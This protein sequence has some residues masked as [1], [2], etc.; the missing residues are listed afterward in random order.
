MKAPRWLEVRV[1]EGLQTLLT[2]RLRN[3]PAADTIEAV[4]EVWLAV[5]MSRSVRWEEARDAPR[6]RGAFL[7]I[8]GS[9]DFWPAPAQVFAAM[10]PPP[11][12]PRLTAPRPGPIPAEVRARLD[13]LLRSM[14][15]PKFTP[16]E[17]P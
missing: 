12:L 16:G 10:P 5:F 14:R 1:I 7:S 6:I 15:S 4:M 8:A 11:E 9:V 2:L 17:K 13:S 3:A